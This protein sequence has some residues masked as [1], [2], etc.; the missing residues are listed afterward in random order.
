M[1]HGVEDTV[2]DEKQLFQ[3][4]HLEINSVVIL[5]I[6]MCVFVMALKT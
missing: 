5:L 1:V 2:K 6:L 3:K 4:R